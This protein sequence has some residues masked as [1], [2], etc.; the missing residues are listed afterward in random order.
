LVLASCVHQA[1]LCK[2]GWLPP[3]ST[4]ARSSTHADENPCSCWSATELLYTMLLC[5]EAVAVSKA[6][7]SICAACWPSA[8]PTC[9]CADMYPCCFATLVVDVPSAC[10]PPHGG[11]TRYFVCNVVVCCI[12]ADNS[13][14]YVGC[15]T[16]HMASRHLD[17]SAR[18]QAARHTQCMSCWNYY[19]YCSCVWRASS[20]FG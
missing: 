16:L 17:V 1:S 9:T 14:Q 12:M 4:Q 8:H 7:A 3:C 18:P 19:R 5:V 13:A 6:V 15:H 10:A 11:I 20:C 2:C